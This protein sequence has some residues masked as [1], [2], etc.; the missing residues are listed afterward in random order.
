MQRWLAS[1]GAALLRAKSTAIPGA[2]RAWLE[3]ES[4][5]WPRR[6]APGMR[7]ALGSIAVALAASADTDPDAAARA[8][9]LADWLATTS[10]T[11]AERSRWEE[12]RKALPAP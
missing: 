11:A 10:P 5:A 2:T 1:T 4:I 9:A 6:D 12:M 7:S 8:R 3:L